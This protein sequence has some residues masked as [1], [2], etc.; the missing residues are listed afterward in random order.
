LTVYCRPVDFGINK[1]SSKE[2]NVEGVTR[3][4]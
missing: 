1:R 4:V 2:R 3:L